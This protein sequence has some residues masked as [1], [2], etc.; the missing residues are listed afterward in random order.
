MADIK[1]PIGEI[2]SLRDIM[3]FLSLFQGK[4]NSNTKQ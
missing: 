4:Y 2:D 1:K 3:A